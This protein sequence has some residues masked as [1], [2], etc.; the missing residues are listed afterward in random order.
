MRLYDLSEQYTDL[1]DLLEQ[2]ADNEQLQTMLDGLEGKIEEKIENTAKV[3]KSLEFNAECIDTEIKR[4]T[5]RKSALTNNITYLKN[6]IEQSMLRLGIDKVT[7]NI[8][9]VAMQNNPPKIQVIDESQISDFFFNLKIDRTLN[10]KKLMDAI[11]NEGYHTMGATIVQE[12]SLRV[13]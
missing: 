1:L 10:R 8:Y 3:M 4:L 9:T 2:D 7:G 12:K 6:N 11:K 13:R 5:S